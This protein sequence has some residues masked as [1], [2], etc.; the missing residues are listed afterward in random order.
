M[1]HVNTGATVNIAAGTYPEHV[2]TSRDIT[3]QASGVVTLLSERRAPHKRESAGGCRL[4]G[5]IR[6]E[7]AV[8]RFSRR[9]KHA[10]ALYLRRG[11]ILDDA[12]LKDAASEMNS[13]LTAQKSAKLKRVK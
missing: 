10:F 8:L 4:C 6:R 3:L 12:A 2:V 7:Y 5:G 11:G 13:F 1:N 9:K